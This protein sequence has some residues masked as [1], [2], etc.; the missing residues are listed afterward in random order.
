MVDPT[1]L[2]QDLR[3]FW[4]LMNLQDCGWENHWQIIMKTHEDPL[5]GRG[6]QFTYTILIWFTNLF[7]CL[8]LW[9]FQ[10]TDTF[11]LFRESRECFSR[12]S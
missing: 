3:S 9:V 1:K 4:K 6:E 2:K 5:A 11:D 12:D 8:K 10:V 7:L